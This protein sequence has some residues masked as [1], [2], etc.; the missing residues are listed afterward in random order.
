MARRTDG[1]PL[2]RAISNRP[3]GLQ[4]SSHLFRTDCSL[5]LI[6]NHPNPTAVLLGL[7]ISPICSISSFA[8][9]SDTTLGAVSGAGTGSAGTGSAETGS[10][11][12]GS[13]GTGSDGA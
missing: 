5:H 2:H 11:G 1:T 9:A 3:L 7:S 8:G 6:C 10:V 12:T 13:A 4:S